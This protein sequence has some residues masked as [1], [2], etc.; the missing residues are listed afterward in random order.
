MQSQQRS[1]FKAGTAQL[2]VISLNA[3]GLNSPKKRILLSSELR[4][5]KAQVAFVQETHFKISSVPRWSNKY[6]PDIHSS[7]PQRNKT[8]GVAILFGRNFNF[9]VLSTKKDPNGRF[10]FVKGTLGTQKLTFANIYLPNEHQDTTFH[11]ITEALL[12]FTEG[13][14]ILGGDMNVPLDPAIDCSKGISSIA[15]NLN[16][17]ITKDLHR[18]Q[19]IDAWRLARPTE[20]NYTFYSAKHD[21]YTRIDYLFLSQHHL[22]DLG[23]VEIFTRSWSDRAPISLSVSLNTDSPRAN[24]WRLNEA[25]LKDTVFLDELKQALTNYFKEDVSPITIWEAHKCYIRGILIQLC[26]RRKKAHKAKHEELLSEIRKLEI[27]HKSTPTAAILSQLVTL[28]TELANH[29]SFH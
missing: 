25:G 23:K 5:L 2:N 22:G 27:T 19:V 28:R 9:K 4:H 1:E 7:I 17:N 3:N 18:L 15:T 13:L 21:V 26:A 24:T 8:K 6:F 14:L 16:R 29:Q 10:V 12:G 20:R 11:T